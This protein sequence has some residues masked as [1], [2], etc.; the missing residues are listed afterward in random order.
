MFFRNSILASS[1]IVLSLAAAAPAQAQV[2]E[3]D[4]PAQPAVKAIPEL[5]RQAQIQIVASARDLNGVRT[6]A[7][8]GR[9][10]AREALRRLI[11]DTP[12]K[13]VSDDGQIV[14]LRSNQTSE[15]DPAEATAAKGVIAGRV[16]N[17]ATGEY[18]RNADHDAAEARSHE[19]NWKNCTKCGNPIGDDRLDALPA[20]ELCVTCKANRGSW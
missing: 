16:L 17:T 20:T 13:I 14:T 15:A 18:V 1:A 5:A 12:L 11:A 7:I 19:R 8:K 6:P 10:D 3:F 4:V 2:R 9:M